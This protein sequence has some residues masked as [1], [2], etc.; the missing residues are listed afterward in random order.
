MTMDAA[1]TDAD[2]TETDTD[3]ENRK[4]CSDESCTGTIGDDR[5]CRVCG[6]ADETA[7]AAGIPPS[8]DTAAESTEPDM[9]DVSAEISG[10]DLPPEDGE[11]EEPDADWENR[12][13]CR[14]ESCIGTLDSNGCCSV[15]GLPY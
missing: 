8:P 7:D 6:L 9:P 10:E 2:C 15:C 14:D 13:L 3:W 1:E 12:K 11:T 5:R 4:L